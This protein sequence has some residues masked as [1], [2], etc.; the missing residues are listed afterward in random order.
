MPEPTAT[1]FDPDAARAGRRVS[2]VSI[3]WTILGSSFAI[4]FG[5]AAASVALVAFGLVGLVDLVGSVALVHH[6]RHAL[7]TDAFSDRFERRAHR[8]V[9]TGLLTIGLATV[10]VSAARLTIGHFPKTSTAEIVI[11]SLSVVALCILSTCKV[12]VARAIPS[13]ALRS[14]GFLTGIGAAQALVILAGTAAARR[15]SWH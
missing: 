4:P 13:A 12:R 7:R 14:D 5:I 2:E 1:A 10:V 6:Y 11:S 15:L 9:I 8:I 3:A